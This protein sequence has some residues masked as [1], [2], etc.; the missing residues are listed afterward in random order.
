MITKKMDYQNRH[1][2]KQIKVRGKWLQVKGIEQRNSKL[3]FFHTTDGQTVPMAF[4]EEW[5]ETT[6]KMSKVR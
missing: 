5:N 3:I 4:V 2:V 6:Q 1:L